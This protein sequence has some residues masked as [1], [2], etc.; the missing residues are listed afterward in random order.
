MARECI[1]VG[2]IGTGAI[3]SLH[4]DNLMRRTMSATVV[5][6]MDIDAQKASAV[7]AACDGA[8]VYADASDLIADPDVDAILI[9]APDV[10]HANFA[11]A[12]IEAGKPVLCEK[13]LAT[14]AADAERIVKAELG[15][16]RRLA[17]VGF[18]REYDRAHRDLLDLLQSG[19]IG[20]ALKFRSAHI[21]PVF[22]REL[23]IDSVITNSL[24]HDIHSARWIMGAEIS[25]AFVQWLPSNPAQP[26]SARLADLQVAFAG[27]AIGS[28]E[29]NGD[30]GYGYEVT[31]EVTG[32]KGMITT[33]AHPSPALR[34]ADAV[35]QAITPN[36]PERFAQA[37]IDEAQDWIDHI[38]RGEAA[39]PSAWDGYMSLL[40]AE[41]AI[42]SSQTGVP[43]PVRAGERPDLY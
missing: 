4:A 41:A 40:A 27:G 43:Q 20:A 23:T 1:K 21:N 10:T 38:R 6:V 39:G 37:Y 16:G 12:C 35:S 15:L 25:R 30:S 31:V 22:H 3:G 29:Y 7:A 8:R 18:M 14:S 9:A 33:A 34:R 17:Q 11:L 32:E 42:R 13:P 5:A 28:L 26:R 36:W 24:I 19:A 2:I